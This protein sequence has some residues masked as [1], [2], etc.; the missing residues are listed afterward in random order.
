MTRGDG[1]LL[2]VLHVTVPRSPAAS[3]SLF[4]VRITANSSVFRKNREFGNL[5]V[6]SGLS[7]RRAGAF[8]N[9]MPREEMECGMRWR[10]CI[11][12]G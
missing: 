11:S 8:P 9:A 3:N 4:F 1:A 7:A 12:T 6:F 5:P 10:L 2:G